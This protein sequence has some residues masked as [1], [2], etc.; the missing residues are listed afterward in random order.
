MHILLSSNA[1]FSAYFQSDL[2]GKLIFI[3]LFLLSITTWSIFI[4]KWSQ[5]RIVRKNSYAF[6][7]QVAAN[8]H[9]PLHVECPPEEQV[10]PFLAIY[11]NLKRTTLEI[12]NKNRSVG[13]QEAFLTSSDLDLVGD[14]VEIA[15]SEQVKG[16]EK[17]LHILSMTVSLAPF[18][19]LLGTVWG[20]LITLSELQHHSALASSGSILTG[21]SMA[22]ATTILGLLIAI[23]AL[24]IFTTLRNRVRELSAEMRD[25]SSDMLGAVEMQYRRVELGG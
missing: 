25:F 14:Q 5:L 9:T 7:S 8:R 20:S 4:K 11:S 10:N 15:I 2:F 16:L 19:G 13:Q 3:S 18:L 6:R 17:N 21:L 1:F 12:L 23:P 24:I 22:L